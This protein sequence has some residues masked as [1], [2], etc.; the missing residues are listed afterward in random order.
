MSKTVSMYNDVSHNAV[1]KG[2]QHDC[3]N[4]S[5]TDINGNNMFSLIS[6][7]SLELKKLE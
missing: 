1:S 7:F 4:P 5:N 2:E 3:T 6:E